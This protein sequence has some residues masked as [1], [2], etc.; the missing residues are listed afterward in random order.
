MTIKEKIKP[1]EIKGLV[2]AF[3]YFFCLLTSYYIIRPLRDEMGIAGGVENL[4]WLFTGTFMVMLI[5]VPF[6]GWVASKNPR[7]KFIPYVYG[8]FI[9]LIITFFLLFS[10][11]TF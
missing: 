8:L 5:A 1:S 10:T 9:S 11:F 7:E 2:W 3:T 6:F 4:P